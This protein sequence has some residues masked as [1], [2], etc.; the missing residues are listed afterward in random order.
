MSNTKVYIALIAFLLLMTL[1]GCGGGVTVDTKEA[2]YTGA[3]RLSWSTPST[4]S[5]GSP[6]PVTNI[7]G[8]RVY[9]RTPSGDYNPGIYYFVSAPSTSVSVKNFNL[10]VGQYY[11]AVKTLDVSNMES[12]FSNEAFADLE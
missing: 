11:F 3:A 7:K 1:V 5:D 6:L 2:I 10:P 12:G 4:N 8:Y 9:F